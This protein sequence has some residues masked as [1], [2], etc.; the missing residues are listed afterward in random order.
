M[1]KQV[2]EK[3]LQLS[4]L[5]V[6]NLPELQGWKEKQ[7]VL[8]KDNPYVEITDNK[9]YEVACKSRT[10]LL[11]G[12]T[13]LEKQDKL[14]AS[15]L[16]TFRKDVK[17]E[18]DN[19]IAITLPF[20]EKQQIEVKRYE[21]IKEA[22]RQEKE[23]IEQ[24]R[25]TTIKS[26]IDSIETD[27][28]GIIQKTT[29]SEIDFSKTQ[30]FA[31]FTIDFD[32][33]EFDILF[34]QVKSRVEVALEE[35]ITSLTESENQRLENIRLEEESKELKRI[36]DLQSLRLNEMLPYVAF[37]DVADLTKLSDIEESVYSELLASKKALFEADVK[38]KKEV[39]DKLDAENLERENKAKA[40]KE[41]IF[42]IR[43]RRLDSILFRICENVLINPALDIELNYTKNHI[44]NC[45][46]IDFESI[47][48]ECEN[49]KL[50]VEESL[51]QKAIDEEVFKKRKEIF[52]SVSLLKEEITHIYSDKTG[53]ISFEDLYNCEIVSDED[54]NF[55]MD[56]V[57]TSVK[58][59][60]EL[61]SKDDAERL[62]KENKARIKRL[63]V[64]KKVVSE[65]I[66]ACLFTD[67]NLET[68]NKEISDFIENSNLRIQEL[69][70][71][72]LTELEKL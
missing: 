43:E 44:L 46:A 62:K 34:E 40:D 70:N 42:V 52:E 47:F 3:G 51:R 32:F 9:T 18:T 36:S 61:Q 39:Q 16:S 28:F 41:K 50:E 37:G 35:K 21:E 2:E 12:R 26:K 56:E 13:E 66:E 65:S 69:K 7:E 58:I 57:R 6:S 55:V 24:E 68:E 17:T 54:F 45:D 14:V 23:R 29:F 27:C 22:E 38:E 63:A 8:V 25:I 20:E 72:L 33:E 48:T 19:L 10:A 64:D 5:K 60:N 53:E 31:F 59:F 30:L 15:K 71:E 11:K 49:A 1:E 4:D 67:L